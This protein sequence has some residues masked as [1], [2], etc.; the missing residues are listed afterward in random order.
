MN[1][2]CELGDYYQREMTRN[3][4]GT[5]AYLIAKAKREA[6]HEAEDI[7]IDILTRYRKEGGTK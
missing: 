3:T 7:I 2:I 4:R 5:D 1:E 6:L